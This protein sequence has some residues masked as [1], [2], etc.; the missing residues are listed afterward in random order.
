MSMPFEQW[1]DTFN[2][3]QE[4]FHEMAVLNIKT[5]EGLTYLKPEN[6]TNFKNPEELL[7]KQIDITFENA[8]K[9]LDYMQESFQIIEK[10]MISLVP[11]SK[12]KIRSK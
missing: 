10:A 9:L 3:S 6:L 12:D 8:H 5:L 2:K 1:R 11:E 7:N 4:P